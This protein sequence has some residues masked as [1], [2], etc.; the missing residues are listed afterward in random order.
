VG[1]LADLPNVGK[2][3][4]SN[5]R[6]VGI[7][8]PDELRRVGTEEAFARIR[9]QVDPGACIRMLYGIEGAVEGI[10]DTQLSTETK[11]QLKQFLKSMG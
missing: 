1:S 10:P 9:A 6:Q 5:L 3:L 8:T 7:T 11:A 4:E 2:V